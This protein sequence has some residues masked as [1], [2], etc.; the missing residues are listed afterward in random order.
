MKIMLDTNVL[1][2]IIVFNSQSL[3]SMM[4]KILQEHQLV[5]S[6]YIIE[7]LKEVVKRRF[8]TKTNDLEIFLQ[9]LVYEYVETPIITDFSLFSIRDMDDYPVLY[10]AILEKVDILI[11]GDKDFS[12][13][14]IE[15]PEIVTPTAFIEKY[16][17]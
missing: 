1:I 7:E 12:D 5:L 6:S 2:S 16:I 10:T 14:I 9:T 11:T 13:V 17:N 15:K 8:S 3:N 4:K